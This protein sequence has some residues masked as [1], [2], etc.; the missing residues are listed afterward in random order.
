MSDDYNIG[1]ETGH[2][3]GYA[4]GFFKAA[5]EWDTGYTALLKERTEIL[6]A[7]EHLKRQIDLIVKTSIKK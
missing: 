4:E 7:L 5:K 3:T 6:H 1:Y 2:K